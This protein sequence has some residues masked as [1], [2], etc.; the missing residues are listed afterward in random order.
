MAIYGRLKRTPTVADPTAPPPAGAPP[1]ETGP[2]DPTLNQPK[3]TDAPQ[4][5][6]AAA[7]P[8]PVD[9]WRSGLNA[10]R[11]EGYHR[12]ATDQEYDYFSQRKAEENAQGNVRPDEFWFDAARGN[13]AGGSDTAQYGRYAGHDFGTLEQ[14]QGRMSLPAPAAWQNLTTPGVNV[15]QA[16]GAGA[17]P[18]AAMG[19]G[20]LVNGGWLPKDHPLAQQAQ[21]AAQAPAANAPVTTQPT[22]TTSVPQQPGTPTNAPPQ[23]Q[24]DDT[25]RQRLLELLN[26]QPITADLL[27]GT[28]EASAYRL[29]SQRSE[30]RQLAQLAEDAAQNGYTGTAEFD[31]KRRGLSE[32]RGEGESQFLG[33]LATQRLTQQRDELLAGIQTAQQSGQFEAAQAMQLQI[34]KMNDAIQRSQ[35]SQQNEQFTQAQGQQNTQFGAAQSLQ[36]RLAQLDAGIRQQQVSQSGQLG[37]ASLELQKL[38]GLGN[39]DLS[40]AQLGQQGS[41][42]N[43]TLGYNYTALQQSANEA[44]VRALLGI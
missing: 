34:A 4:D 17:D 21:Q 24:L 32:Q 29:G 33:N 41:Q 31:A 42:F 22:P 7:A 23:G 12:D 30:E 9:P 26:P 13:G 18:F 3:I 39:L 5:P 38:L 15:S 2:V 14:Q 11:Q 36:E 40:R 43:S 27:N 37:N 25:V 1:M 19:G 8:P 35:M 6:G 16:A 10:A 44:A 20:V 28:P